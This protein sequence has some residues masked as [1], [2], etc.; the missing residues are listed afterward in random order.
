MKFSLPLHLGS[1]LPGIKVKVFSLRYCDATCHSP[2]LL[3]VHLTSVK[4]TVKFRKIRR[5]IDVKIRFDISN[6]V[7][8]IALNELLEFIVI[9]FNFYLICIGKFT[10]YIVENLTLC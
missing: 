4:I 3:P 6:K 8:L 1:A 5:Y 9:V 10:V 2:L 7:S